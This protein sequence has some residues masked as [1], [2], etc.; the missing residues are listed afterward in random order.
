[1]C[2]HYV[3]VIAIDL[4]QEESSTVRYW[5]LYWN[6]QVLRAGVLCMRAVESY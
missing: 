3:G 5:V 2:D 4:D 1:M 6:G